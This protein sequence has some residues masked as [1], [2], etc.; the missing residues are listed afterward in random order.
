MY[1]QYIPN[2]YE[3]NTDSILKSTD[4]THHIYG[5][6][7]H[8]SDNVFM[9]HTGCLQQHTYGRYGYASRSFMTGTGITQT[10][11]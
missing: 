7:G 5:R 1:G 2:R 4:R 9:V 10:A 8:V 6:Y 3:Q 11:H